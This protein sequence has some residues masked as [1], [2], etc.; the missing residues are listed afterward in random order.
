[1]CEMSEAEMVDDLTGYRNYE[2]M[3]KLIAWLW[4]EWVKEAMYRA[5]GNA[6]EAAR[7]TGT[8]VST[9]GAIKRRYGR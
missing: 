5:G 2:E 9:F 7:Q 6:S 8:G 1:M 3:Q 4:E